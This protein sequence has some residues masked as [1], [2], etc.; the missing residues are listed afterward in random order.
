MALPT[1][2]FGRTGHISSRTLF[3]A[4]ALGSVRQEKADQVL[5]LL[6]E[7]GVNHIDT[8]ASYGES[9]LRIGPWMKRHRAGF[10]LA[11][12]T[13]ERSYQGAKDSLHRSLERLQ[14]DSVDLIQ[15]HNLVNL[16][17]WQEAMGPSGALEALI[18]AKEQ[19]LVRFLGVTG[20]GTRVAER[21]L[22]SIE[23]Y[24]FDSVLLPYNFTMMSQPQYAEDFEKLVAVCRQR[25]IAI[26]TIKAIARRRWPSVKSENEAARRF[27]WYEPIR[28]PAALRDAVAWVM[29]RHDF[30]LNTSS[31][32]TLLEPTLDA[33]EA[34]VAEGI[35]PSDE[36]MQSHV[37]AQA[38]EPLFV[39]GV[40]EGVF[41]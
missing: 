30:F 2:N 18:E 9:E 37:A 3:G 17:D 13:G 23:R 19:G 16:D 11:T 36:T 20:H 10:F 14:V 1:H 8:A 25:G 5:E 27:S 34:A 35:E 40:Q 32:L 38:A 4:A 24:P 28:D 29:S 6:L 39:R 33:A 41:D 26:Q 22:D 31:D 15:M 21:H 12:K 7:R